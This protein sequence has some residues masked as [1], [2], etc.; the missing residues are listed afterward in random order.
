MVLHTLFHLITPVDHHVPKQRRKAEQN[1]KWMVTGTC[2]GPWERLESNRGLWNAM[3]SPQCMALK[4]I[5]LLVLHL[6]N[7][8]F[9]ASSCKTEAKCYYL[10]IPPMTVQDAK[11]WQ[12]CLHRQAVSIQP[13]GRHTVAAYKGNHAEGPLSRR[14]L[15]VVQTTIFSSEIFRHSLAP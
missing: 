11:Q 10:L 15:F 12:K 2:A 6:Q 1:R 13:K 4:R 7:S 14:V 9:W 5:T 3:L 8:I